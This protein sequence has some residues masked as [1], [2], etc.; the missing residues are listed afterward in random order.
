M[1][2]PIQPAKASVNLAPPGVRGSRIRRD[3]PPPVKKAA[4]RDRG[5][6]DRLTVI[7]GISTFAIALL[8]IVVALTGY[9]GWTPS[10]YVIH[11]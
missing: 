11:F 9:D 1:A 3:P 6:R 5:E 8:I 2:S 10:Q 7:A 4:V